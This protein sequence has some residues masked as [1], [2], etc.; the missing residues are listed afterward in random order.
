M[1]FTRSPGK[2]GSDKHTFEEWCQME[3]KTKPKKPPNTTNHKNKAI[4]N[5]ELVKM[6]I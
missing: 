3:K 5:K 1:G 6:N 4:Y 2:N